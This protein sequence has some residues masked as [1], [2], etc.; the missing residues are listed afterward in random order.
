MSLIL[1]VLWKN[2]LYLHDFCS[3]V[4]WDGIQLFADFREIQSNSFFSSWHSK[5]YRCGPWTYGLRTV[6]TTGGTD[7]TDYRRKDYGRNGL[8]TVRTTDGGKKFVSFSLYF[9]FI[10]DFFSLSSLEF[11]NF[12]L[13]FSEFVFS[14]SWVINCRESA[15]SNHRFRWHLAVGNQFTVKDLFFPSSTY[16]IWAN[17]WLISRFFQ[18][19][20]KK[21]P[22]HNSLI[23]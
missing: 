8:R 15:L 17:H 12:F 6:W 7:G 5:N 4:V 2:K 3:A 13:S 11:V 9:R 23:C 14:L 22:L 16:A 20:F 10:H 18:W 19:N 21:F 1:I